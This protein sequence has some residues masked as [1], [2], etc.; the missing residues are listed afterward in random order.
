MLIVTIKN[1]QS[2]DPSTDNTWEVGLGNKKWVLLHK[3]EIQKP[4]DQG[5]PRTSHNRQKTKLRQK[6]KQSST[7]SKY[8]H[9]SGTVSARALVS[10]RIWDHFMLS[11]PMLAYAYDTNLDNVRYLDFRTEWAVYFLSW[12]HPIFPANKWHK[13]AIDLKEQL[14]PQTMYLGM[15]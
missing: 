11:N 1:K 2:E 15:K 10:L 14:N 5:K 4:R 7:K 13:S 6:L 12:T 3:A 9:D 8:K